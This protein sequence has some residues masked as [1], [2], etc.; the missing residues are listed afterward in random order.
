MSINDMQSNTKFPYGLL[1]P[2]YIDE[3]NDKKWYLLKIG[4]RTK[5]KWIE[6]SNCIFNLF[7][8]REIIYINEFNKIEGFG[9]SWIPINF[10]GI[11]LFL[12]ATNFFNP[13]PVGAILNKKFV[14]D[15]YIDVLS[16]NEKETTIPP[17]MLSK[18]VVTIYHRLIKQKSK[19]K[20][21][22]FTE[23][24]IIEE[25]LNNDETKS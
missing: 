23:E 9:R 8:F 19:D 3:G 24:E 22:L 16:K 15:L 17:Y 13:K 2:Y 1:S 14:A 7:L 12:Q 20:L 5:P 6:K 11:K 18:V 21:L 4:I 10:F 25:G